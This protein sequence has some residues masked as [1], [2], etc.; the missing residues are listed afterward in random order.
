[1]YYD[2]LP[3][4]GK[5]E[6]VRMKLFMRSLT[7]EALTWYIDH[8]TRKWSSWVDMA[9]DIMDRFHFNTENVPD[10]FY[11]QNLKKNPGETFR[12]YAVR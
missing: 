8:D 7:G 10:K 1:M 11:I 5:D 6:R 9:S 3:G 4:V 12:D 2:K